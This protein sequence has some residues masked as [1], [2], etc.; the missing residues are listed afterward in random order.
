MI[1]YDFIFAYEIKSLVILSAF[2]NMW[3]KE[4]VDL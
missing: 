3:V 4:A 2:F 1:L